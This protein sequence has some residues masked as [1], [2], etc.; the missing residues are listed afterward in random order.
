[1]SHRERYF[2]G[3]FRRAAA[4]NSNARDAF[5]RRMQAKLRRS[6]VRRIVRSQNLWV[7][8]DQGRAGTGG[9]AS[10]SPDAPPMAAATLAR[11]SAPSEACGFF[12]GSAARCD[13]SDAGA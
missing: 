9:K 3:D 6:A 8:F 11:R 1:M 2:G 4:A 12:A 5:F 13:G 7:F 10:R